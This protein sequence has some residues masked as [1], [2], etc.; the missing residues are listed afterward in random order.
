[1][2]IPYI[3]DRHGHFLSD[4]NNSSSYSYQD[5]HISFKWRDGINTLQLKKTTL[6]PPTASI[7]W[8]DDNITLAS[9]LHDTCSYQ[10]FVIGVAHSVAAVSICDQVVRI[11]SVCDH[12]SLIFSI[13]DHVF[14]KF[15]TC[16]HVSRISICFVN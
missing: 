4:F 11:I 15:F 6:S 10:G 12:V 2:I 14:R 1:M 5:L 16:D 8:E 3:S 9:G 7:V 13:C